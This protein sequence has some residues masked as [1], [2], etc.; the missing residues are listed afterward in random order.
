MVYIF[1]RL[2]ID[3]QEQYIFC[4]EALLEAIRAGQT[5]VSSASFVN[6]VDTLLPEEDAT[7]DKTLLQ[8]QY[9]VSKCCCCVEFGE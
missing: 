5:E 8:L 1:V 9:E 4:H 3:L 6:Y 2:L 7:N